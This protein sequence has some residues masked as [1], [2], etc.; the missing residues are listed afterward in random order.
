MKNTA[1]LLGF[2]R[3]AVLPP[4]KS[5]EVLKKFF[6]RPAVLPARSKGEPLAFGRFTERQADVLL[7]YNQVRL[8]A[9][10]EGMHVD[11]FV[12]DN[13]MQNPDPNVAY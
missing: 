8:A 1:E 11:V 12:P 4:V 13:R 6:G 9:E 5:G 2:H 7:Q 3:D 10:N